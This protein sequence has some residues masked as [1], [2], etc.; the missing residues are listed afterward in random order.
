MSFSLAST[1]RIVLASCAAVTILF[2]PTPGRA[3]DAPAAKT[4]EPA[5]VPAKPIFADKNLENAVRKFVFEKR[6]NDKP[7]VEADLV[8][9]STIQ[10]NSQGITNLLGLEKCV[11]LA[12]LDIAGNKISDLSPLKGL[13]KLQYLNLATNLVVDVSPLA[14]V[15]ALQYLELTKNKVKE[16]RPLAGL[17][18]MASLYLAA[19][20]ISDVSIVSKLTKLASLY[21][22]SNKIKTIPPLKDL[23][24]LMSLSL[25][26][27]TI[28]DLGP[29]NGITP[30]HLF[31]ENNR[32]KDLTPLVIMAKTDAD[33]EKRF[34]PF[35]N[36]YIKGNPLS[37]KAKSTQ[38]SQLKEIGVRLNQ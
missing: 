24:G 18:N 6:D 12:S 25:S 1:R 26:G 31:L 27:N 13:S 32:I 8:N 7:L 30:Y 38:L 34:A 36:L 33:G 5:P 2:A 3:A 16:I 21:L 11:N 35:L 10:A 22:D 14:D 28:S 20:A 4:P 19:N 23:R 15:R 37:S 17:T 9:L 29:L